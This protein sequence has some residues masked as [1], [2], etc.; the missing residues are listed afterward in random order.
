MSTT[1]VAGRAISDWRR[2][3]LRRNFLWILVY[4]RPPK[5]VFTRESCR[6]LLVDLGVTVWMLLEISRLAY[7]LPITTSVHVSEHFLRRRTFFIVAE[8]GGRFTSTH[9]AS[10]LFSTIST[11]PPAVGR[12]LPARFQLLFSTLVVIYRPVSTTSGCNWTFGSVEQESNATH[13]QLGRVLGGSVHVGCSCTPRNFE[14][15]TPLSTLPLSG[16]PLISIEQAAW[17]RRD[18][19]QARGRLHPKP[20]KSSFYRK[21]ADAEG[22][23]RAH[24]GFFTM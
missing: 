22:A 4:S 17:S 9:T 1:A 7:Y 20:T 13:C 5:I 2:R 11:A 3:V 16:D 14:T 19:L 10:L 23:N 12:P 15:Q 6:T 8:C 18:L 24:A 21:A